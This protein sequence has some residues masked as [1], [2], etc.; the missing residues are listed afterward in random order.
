VTAGFDQASVGHRQA[1]TDQEISRRSEPVPQRSRIVRRNDAADCRAVEGTVDR[2]PLTVSRELLIELLQRDA[3]V[4]RD[5]EIAM[6]MHDLRVQANGRDDAID[7][8]RRAPPAELRTTAAQN[9]D[10]PIARR[11]RERF[12]DV[13]CALRLDDLTRHNTIDGIARAALTNHGSGH[14]ETFGEARFFDGMFPVTDQALRRRAAASG[15]L[16]LDY[17]VGVDRSR[18]ASAASHRDRRPKTSSACSLSCRAD[19]VLT[20]DRSAG[21][22]AVAQNLAGHFLGE[23]RLAG[24]RSS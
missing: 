20:G 6:A 13:G 3:R 4:R 16:C 8:D 21:L 23:R 22:D 24:M 9:S 5:G 7:R 15:A 18:R 14:R 1:D 17:T 12:G 11:G 2:K 10:E 19:A